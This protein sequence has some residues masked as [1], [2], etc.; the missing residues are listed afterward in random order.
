MTFEEQLQGVF[1]H[2]ASLE[3]FQEVRESNKHKIILSPTLLLAFVPFFADQTKKPDLHDLKEK[4]KNKRRPK[5]PRDYLLPCMRKISSLAN[6]ILKG[7]GATRG[8]VGWIPIAFHGPCMYLFATLNS[9][10]RLDSLTTFSNGKSRQENKEKHKCITI[11]DELRVIYGAQPKYANKNGQGVT[12]STIPS[13]ACLFTDGEIFL[14]SSLTKT[15]TPVDLNPRYLRELEKNVFERIYNYAKNSRLPCPKTMTI[16]D[17]VLPLSIPSI[18]DTIRAVLPLRIDLFATDALRSR[19][20]VHRLRAGNNCMI[21][22]IP[23]CLT[24]NYF[25]S[26]RF[27]NRLASLNI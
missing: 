11:E 16:V 3:A 22:S 9:Y 25:P 20:N 6:R 14:L 10:V 8:V 7:K 2:P 24:Q 21:L 4:K 19:F 17:D 26:H 5:K 1:C 12:I 18:I 27:V 23:L 13:F 15:T